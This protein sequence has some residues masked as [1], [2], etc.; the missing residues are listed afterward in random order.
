[1]LNKYLLFHNIEYLL[2]LL[3]ETILESQEHLSASIFRIINE[4]PLE[5]TIKQSKRMRI[6]LITNP[7]DSIINPSLS[8]ALDNFMKFP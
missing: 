1:M 2:A 5:H 8:I 3:I 6:I 4:T 7:F